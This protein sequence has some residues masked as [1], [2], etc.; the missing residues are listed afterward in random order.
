MTLQKRSFLHHA[1]FWVPTLYLAMGLPF[2]A[3]AACP[4]NAYLANAR[5]AKIATGIC[6]AVTVVILFTGYKLGI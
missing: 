5:G 3:S 1:L 6:A 4:G 2:N